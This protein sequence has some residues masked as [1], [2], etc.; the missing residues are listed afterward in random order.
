MSGVGALPAQFLVE[1]TSVDKTHNPETAATSYPRARK[2]AIDLSA[3][4][5]RIGHDLT[6][7]GVHPTCHRS[8]LNL[9][10]TGPIVAIEARHA[11][12]RRDGYRKTGSP[13]D[14]GADPAHDGIWPTGSAPARRSPRGGARLPVPE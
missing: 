10:V 7:I 5:S 11:K 9:Q 13:G 4:I 12:I 1:I 8:N 2:S 14:R 6:E 3:I